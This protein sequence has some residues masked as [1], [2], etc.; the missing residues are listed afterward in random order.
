MKNT[1]Y[2]IIDTGFDPQIASY[3]YSEKI[4]FYFLLLNN[5]ENAPIIIM[6]DQLVTVLQRTLL[7]E[8]VIKIAPILF[9]F[10]DFFI[11]S[12]QPFYRLF[13]YP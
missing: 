10:S 11:I 12:Q 5:S 6:A 7:A 13:L 8:I 4:S 9:V 2:I 3:M 1:T